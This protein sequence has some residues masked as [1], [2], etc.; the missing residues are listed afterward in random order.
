MLK[1]CRQSKEPFCSS[2]NIH[3]F[4]IIFLLKISQLSDD[5]FDQLGCFSM[6]EIPLAHC[7][8]IPGA[9]ISVACVSL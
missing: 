5:S 7:S 3:S 6:V 8:A 4:N 2:T 1:L 9:V